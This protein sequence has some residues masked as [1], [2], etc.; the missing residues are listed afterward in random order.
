MAVLL[1]LLRYVV[2][3]M[4]AVSDVPYCIY[5]LSS[6]TNCFSS[7]RGQSINLFAILP[8]SHGPQYGLGD[9]LLLARSLDR[10][11]VERIGRLT[12]FLSCWRNLQPR[13]RAIADSIFRWLFSQDGVRVM[14]LL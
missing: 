10:C 7:R 14:V 3:S 9:H 12:V 2:C 11:C 5:C 13:L 4:Q 6:T 1:V 8:T